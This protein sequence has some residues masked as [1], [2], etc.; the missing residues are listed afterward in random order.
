ML[1]VYETP[2]SAM[3]LSSVSAGLLP[4]Q[5]RKIKFVPHHF[6]PK[7]QGRDQSTLGFTC[8]SVHSSENV[9]QLPFTK[10][11]TEKD[12]NKE[13]PD[14]TPEQL[15]ILSSLFRGK[16]VASQKS[17]KPQDFRPLP[18]PM[19]HK[20]RPIGL[21][22]PKKSKPNPWKNSGRNPEFLFALARELSSIPNDEQ[23]PEVLENSYRFL[24]K[25][26]LVCVI[27][28]LAL[29]G[30]I[31]RALQT[32]CWVQKKSPKL[33]PDERVLAAILEVLAGANELKT[34]ETFSLDEVLIGCPV[35]VYNAVARGF[36]RSRDFEKAR[37]VM[38]AAKDL[39]L[40]FDDNICATFF[41]EA[42][43]SP[44]THKVAVKLL[45]E[46]GCKQKLGLEIETC[47][48]VMKGCINLGM[49]DEVEKIFEWWKSSGR[50]LT[51][52]IYT[53]LMHSRYCSGRYREGLSVV[54]EM[55]EANCL[56]DLPAL[57]VVIRLCAKLG[58]LARAKRYF[59]RMKDLGL[60]VPSDVY[61]NMVQ[62]YA[63][64]GRWKKCQE[65][66]EEMQMEGFEP[67]SELSKYVYCKISEQ[68]SVMRVKSKS[69]E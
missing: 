56:F 59:A 54:W 52:V 50:R 57:R 40:D 32:F 69:L 33:Y 1:S 35:S 41:L 13:E 48:T 51:V 17:N 55:E 63:M 6:S 7:S 44:R 31:Q 3:N 34:R 43:K 9:T 28:E 10:L 30:Q 60:F 11:E 16:G 42:S 19:P 12:L 49:F 2:V 4:F 25:G 22:L 27:R 39:G 46:M 58:E 64:N 14:W 21:P 23:V 29:M 38:L 45:E 37:Q 20:I 66:L 15:E 61:E 65:T 26:S 8:R 18:L 47:S 24:R 62:L 67:P 68:H 36:I 53:T 5:T